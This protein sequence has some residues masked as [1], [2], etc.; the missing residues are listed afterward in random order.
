[1][2]TIVKTIESKFVKKYDHRQTGLAMFA[3]IIPATGLAYAVS[4]ALA[5]S[6]SGS[7]VK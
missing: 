1:M 5:L 4:I 6:A 3:V 7:C 2:R